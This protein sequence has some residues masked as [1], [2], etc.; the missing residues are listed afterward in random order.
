LSVDLYPW[1]P[2]DGVKVL[3]FHLSPLVDPGAC[4]DE[5]PN[6]G[7]IP[8]IRVMRHRPGTDDGLTERGRYSIFT[9]ALTARDAYGLSDTVRRRLRL[10]ASRFGGQYP[11]DLPSGRVYADDV[12]ILEGPEPVEYIQD[13]IP[14]KFY[15]YSLICEVHFRY[16]AT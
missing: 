6:D 14:R 13:S 10:L 7:P 15:C 11:V 1:A 5:R 3:I 2:P 12:K 9:F 8:F 16:M 4:R